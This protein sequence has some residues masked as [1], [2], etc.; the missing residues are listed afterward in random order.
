MFRSQ[1]MS[2][3]EL[4]VPEHDIVAVTEVL[5]ASGVFQPIQTSHLSSERTPRYTGDW[6]EQVPLFV[7]LEQ[8]ILGVMEALGVDEGPPATEMPHLIEPEVAEMDVE[9]LEQEAQAPIRE[10][11]EEQR[12]LAQLQRQVGQLQI[13]ADLNVELEALCNL[14]YTFVLLGTMPVANLERLQTSLE[15]VP[16]ALVVLRRGEH[17]ATVVLVGTQRD[18]DILNRAAR[19]AYLNPLNLPGTCRGTPAEAIEAMEVGISRARQRIEEYEATIDHLYETRVHH[20]RHLLWRLRASRTLAET[21]AGYGR[22]RYTYLVA[23]WTPTSQ[24]PTLEERIKQVSDKVLVEVDTPRRQ[25]DASIPIM[26]GNPPVMRA[27][28]GL[29]T[30]Y[31]HPG[32]AELDPTPVIA[33]TFPFIFG[34]MFGDLGHGLVLALLGLLLISRKVQS[35]RGLAGQGVLLTACGVMSMICGALYG[36]VFGLESMF[37]PLWFRPLERIMDILIITVGIG[38]GLLTL[39]MFLNIINAALAHR[40]G[41]LIFDHNGLAGL[42]FYW[43]LIGLAAGFL[44]RDIS[45][46]GPGLFVTLAV[47]SGLTVAF[48]EVLG[49]LVEGHRPLIEGGFGTYLVQLPIELF[50]VLIGLFSNTLSYVRMGAFAVAHGALSMV[51]ILIAEAIGPP[52]GVGHWVVV[53]L[54][55]LFIIGFEGM[56]VGIQTLRLEYYEFFSKFFSGGG[57]RYRPLRLVPRGKE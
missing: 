15:L 47:A 39:G 57:V 34:I 21:I 22:L 41:R 52:S 32:Y 54:G 14:R 11:E 13:I 56:I 10:L 44:A 1:T 12:R 16:S 18:A 37:E 27:F 48:A 49:N 20:L 30:N 36:S 43:S 9:H 3:V 46:P 4:A 29:V 5:G 35:L 31:G 19:S 38:V 42:V 23:G 33:L 45:L 26:L 28:Q 7:A 40:W 2:R 50:E 8:R 6:K 17:L 24:L 51:V 25:D 53:A 55:N